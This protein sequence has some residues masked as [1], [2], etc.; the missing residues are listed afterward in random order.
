MTPV[1]AFTSFVALGCLVGLGWTAGGLLEETWRVDVLALAGPRFSFMLR[2][3][4]CL[5]LSWPAVF[6]TEQG[7]GAD[8][9]GLRKCCAQAEEARS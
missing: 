4:S 1:S 6:N 5:S 7:F 9:N 3:W 2:R 8:A